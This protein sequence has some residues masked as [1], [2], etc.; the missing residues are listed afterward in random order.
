MAASPGFTWIALSTFAKVNGAVPFGGPV[1]GRAC[2]LGRR[3]VGPK[4]PAITDLWTPVTRSRFLGEE[5]L[6]LTDA[7]QRWR[8]RRRILSPGGRSN[9]HWG[10]RNR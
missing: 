10:I 5:V 7:A 4:T 2:C 3:A 1:A 6:M 8:N 9:P